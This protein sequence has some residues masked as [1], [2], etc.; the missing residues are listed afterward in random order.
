MM[1]GACYIPESPAYKRGYTLF[2]INW[3]V[4]NKKGA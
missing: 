3:F 2:G 4:K 1:S